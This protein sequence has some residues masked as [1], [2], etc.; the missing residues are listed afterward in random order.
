MAALDAETAIWTAFWNQ[1]APTAGNQ[2][3]ERGCIRRGCIRR[4]LTHCN[5]CSRC[6]SCN[7]TKVY[8][9]NRTHCLETVAVSGVQTV[10][11]FCFVT[12]IQSNNACTAC[13]LVS[14]FFFTAAGDSVFSLV[15]DSGIW[16]VKCAG[17][18]TC[19]VAR[20]TAVRLRKRE[21]GSVRKMRQKVSR[22][23]LSRHYYRLW[24]H[25][26]KVF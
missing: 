8:E 12:E 1:S 21:R 7:Q 5:C 20:I 23:K 24:T 3:T 16:R 15:R 25:I 6:F 13:A 14:E 22:E 2:Y 4:H 10:T 17:P 11:A 9:Q 18:S 26:H 19:W